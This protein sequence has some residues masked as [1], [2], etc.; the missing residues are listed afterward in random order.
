MKVKSIGLKVKL[1][2]NGTNP[3]CIK[4]LTDLG[5]LDAVS[6]DIK[7]LLN[8]GDYSKVTNIHDENIFKKVMV[9]INILSNASIDV[10][11]R[12]TILPGIHSADII[13][14]LESTF[15]QNNY[16]LQDFRNGEVLDKI[17]FFEEFV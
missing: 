13:E 15:Q 11:F 10:Q 8:P 9:S 16:L 17:P 12:T 4:Q 5:L 3:D 7:N 14:K 6:M 1:D 2:T